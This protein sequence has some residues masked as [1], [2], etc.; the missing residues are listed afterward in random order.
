MLTSSWQIFG[1]EDREKRDDAKSIQRT[2]TTVLGWFRSSREVKALYPV[3]ALLCWKL[4][5][6]R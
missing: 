1:D 4:S 3:F 5:C 6:P 2:N